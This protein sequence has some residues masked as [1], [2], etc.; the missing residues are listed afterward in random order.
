MAWLVE[1]ENTDHP[2]ELNIG[3]VCLV[4]I[5]FLRHV[6]NFCSNSSKNFTGNCE[7]KS[8]GCI[9][10]LYLDVFFLSQFTCTLLYI[11]P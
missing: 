11:L 4:N 10:L 8:L 6:G 5:S 2:A 7:L 9:L 1:L 3:T